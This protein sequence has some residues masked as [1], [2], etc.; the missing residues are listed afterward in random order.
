MPVLCGILFGNRLDCR[1]PSVLP[2]GL[3]EVVEPLLGLEILLDWLSHA[4]L[5]LCHLSSTKQ[6]MKQYIHLTTY[7]K[8]ETT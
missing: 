6:E 1:D 3:E 4:L 7:A 2:L 8:V 5:C